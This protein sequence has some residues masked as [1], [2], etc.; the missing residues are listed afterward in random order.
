VLKEAQSV[1]M[2][3]RYRAFDVLRTA[4]TTAKQMW[5]LE[6][7]ENIANDSWV[8]SKEETGFLI[9]RLLS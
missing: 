1:W 4:V 6:G 9:S 8:N 3:I 5:V 2:W 7:M